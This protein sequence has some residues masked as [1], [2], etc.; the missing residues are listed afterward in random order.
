MKNLT[1]LLFLLISVSLSAQQ[2]PDFSLFRENAFVYNPAV[3]GTDQASIINLSV[4][5]QWT[6]INESPFTAIASYHTSIESKNIGVGAVIFNDFIGPT[7]FTGFTAR[8]AAALVVAGRGYEIVEIVDVAMGDAPRTCAFNAAM[9]RADLFPVG[10]EPCS[11][12]AARCG[13]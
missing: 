7:S 8:C 12:G 11:R 4:R 13:C 3:A 10:V 6:N 5:K 1:T 2:I 9:I